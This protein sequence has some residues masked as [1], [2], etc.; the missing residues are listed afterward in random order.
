MYEVGKKLIVYWRNF[1][2]KS[3][4]FEVFEPKGKGEKGN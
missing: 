3:S 2:G 1:E 4:N